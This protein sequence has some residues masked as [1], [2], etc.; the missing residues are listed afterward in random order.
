MFLAVEGGCVVFEVNEQL[1]GIVGLENSFCFALVE[2]IAFNHVRSSLKLKTF[3]NHIDVAQEKFMVEAVGNFFR[4][5]IFRDVGVAFN[6]CFEVFAF[7][8]AFH[9]VALNPFVSVLT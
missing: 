8:P 6:V 2:K 9:C 3:E 5:E 1:V 4:A 7:E